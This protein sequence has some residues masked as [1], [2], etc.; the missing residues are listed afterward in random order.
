MSARREMVVVGYELE[1]EITQG[2]RAVHSGVGFQSLQHTP[3]GPVTDWPTT[4]HWETNNALLP[5]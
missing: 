5:A 3:R 4:G 2:L 1:H